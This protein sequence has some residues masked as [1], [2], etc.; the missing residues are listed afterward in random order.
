MS[1]DHLY[2]KAN[3]MTIFTAIIPQFVQEEVESKVLRLGRQLARINAPAMSVRWTEAAP[4]YLY[5]GK[6]H[7]EPGKGMYQ[8]VP[9]VELTLEYN[10]LHLPGDWIFV[11]SMEP[12]A[13]ENI[14][15]SIPGENIPEEFRSRI[16]TCDH[17]KTSRRRS[18]TFVV[19]NK[20]TGEY[21]NIGRSCLKA[22]LG[23]D[24]SS[25]LVFVDWFGDLQKQCAAD[26][27]NYGAGIHELPTVM[28]LAYVAKVI[29]VDG[30]CP[31]SGS[32]NPTCNIV[33]D[34]LTDRKPSRW[35]NAEWSEYVQA[36]TP[37][38]FE[39]DQLVEDAR[40]W[41]DEQSRDSDFIG[42]LQIITRQHSVSW[43]NRGFCAS[44]IPAYTK[45]Q[46][47]KVE[48][49]TKTNEY[50]PNV[51]LKDRV[52]ID[53]TVLKVIPIEGTFGTSGL[54]VMEDPEGRSIIWFGSGE[55]LS[56]GWSGKIKGTV[57]KFTERNGILQT[58]INR[59]KAL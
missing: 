18:E 12:L 29:Q 20:E 21:K 59:V 13:G 42:N 53:V 51:Q 22:F 28:F 15:R 37:A 10:I 19:K 55:W 27:W 49:K 52:E 48:V 9:H 24:P 7:D 26:Q 14:M 39:F 54:H 47:R 4:K 3:T 32:G 46:V 58:Q 5:A 36:R 50:L 38:P 45:E 40:K 43:R 11:G 6:I 41:I 25:V 33:W 8:V 17:C 30:W 1:L 56:E 34:I 31:K 2:Q 23:Y 57:I 35:S 44:L 16:L